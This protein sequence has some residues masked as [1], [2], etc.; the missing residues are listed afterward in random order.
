MNN[1]SSL[2]HVH[3]SQVKSSPYNLWVEGKSKRYRD[4]VREL[5]VTLQR[6]NLTNLPPIIIVANRKLGSGGISSYNHIDDVIYFN[7][8]FHNTTNTKNVIADEVFAAHN[9][10]DI[11]Q[12]EMGHKLHWDA[13]KRFYSAHPK[14]I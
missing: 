9:L 5:N 7:N 13:A 6:L 8:Y 12:H 10:G 14:Q 2:V 11:I 1:H 3:V 4:C